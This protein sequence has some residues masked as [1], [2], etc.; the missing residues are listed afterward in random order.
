[1]QKTVCVKPRCETTRR[2]S[3]ESVP[4]KPAINA[5]TMIAAS[6]KGMPSTPR[7]CAVFARR[8][9][10]RQTSPCNGNCRVSISG[11]IAPSVAIGTPTTTAPM[12]PCVR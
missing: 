12:L 6:A 4:R 11:S 10:P 3:Q 9:Q 8:F 2:T 5:P 1:M 7:D